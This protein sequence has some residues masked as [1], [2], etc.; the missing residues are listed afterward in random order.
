MSA[1]ST[2]SLVASIL[3][4][5]SETHNP[6]AGTT[7]IASHA[8]A[9]NY[10]HTLDILV[11]SQF[12]QAAAAFTATLTI[13]D[14]SIAGA[15]LAQLNFVTAAAGIDRFNQRVA[16]PGL[17]ANA[18]NAAWEPPGTSITQ[19]VAISGYSEVNN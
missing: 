14:A 19:K 16:I 18:I 8:A 12:N 9:A 10:R 6:A 5:W 4:R 7:A 3:Q 17:V 13:R 11:A 1:K 2:E 15:I